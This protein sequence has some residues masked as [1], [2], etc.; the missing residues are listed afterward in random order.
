MIW[1]CQISAWW[2][3]L[4]YWPWKIGSVL[5][6]RVRQTEESKWLEEK[7]CSSHCAGWAI[8]LICIKKLYIQ[9]VTHKIKIKCTVHHHCLYLEVSQGQRAIHLALHSD[10]GWR[11][12]HCPGPLFLWLNVHHL[13]FSL[14]IWPTVQTPYD[15]TVI[16]LQSNNVDSISLS[17]PC[18]YT[19]SNTR[20]GNLCVVKFCFITSCKSVFVV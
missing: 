10:L 8:S 5:A 13:T 12:L 4:V 6:E 9:F 20:S 19:G 7:L 14:P 1:N 2:C 18:L 17:N 3:Y 11:F 15:E 16:I